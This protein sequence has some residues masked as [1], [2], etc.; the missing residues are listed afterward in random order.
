MREGSEWK[1]L[2]VTGDPYRGVDET[3]LDGISAFV[4]DAYVNELEHTVKRPGT[5]VYRNLGTSVPVDGVY[6]W[7]RQNA[8]IYVSGGRVFQEKDGLVKEIT[9]ATLQTGRKVSF[10]TDGTKLLMANGGQMVHMTLDGVLTTMADAD[11]PTTVS[12]VAYLDGYVFANN[13]NTGQFYRSAISDLTSWAAADFATAEG[14]P[15]DIVALHEGWNELVLVGRESIEFWYHDGVTPFSRIQGGVIQ[16]GCEAPYTFAQAGDAWMYLNKDRR[17]V[18]VTGRTPQPVSFPFDRFI[19]DLTTV[20]EAIAD[21]VDVAGQLFYVVTFPIADRTLVY[22]VHRKQWHE[23]GY[24]DT[25]TTSY[26]RFIGQHHAYARAWNKHLIG[27]RETGLIYELKRG[28]YAD[29]ANDDVIRSVRRT[30]FNS[31][32][33]LIRKRSHALRMRLKRGLGHVSESTGPTNPTMQVRY[34]DTAGAWGNERA[35]SL[36][37]VGQ[38]ELVAE[39]RQ[40]GMYT[41]RQWE[42]I[43]A[44]KTDWIL[45]EAQELVEPLPR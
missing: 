18:Q 7:D 22:N 37:Q 19:Q 31:H 11:A 39:L 43:H 34:R 3:E 45:S 33:S 25:N 36:G 15:D 29:G 30:G 21:V 8:A 23:W 44:D 41:V 4:I 42:F 17:F 2:P 26:R 12:H 35:V 20:S 10:A 6:W 13:L 40:L 16:D 28:H 9:G 27:D 38:H 32:G 14:K 5:L 1:P 24:W